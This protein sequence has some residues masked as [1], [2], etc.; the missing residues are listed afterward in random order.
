MIDAH[1]RDALAEI[2]H[3]Q[4][5]AGVDDLTLGALTRRRQRDG[6]KLCQ[7]QALL[8]VGR[9]DAGNDLVGGVVA[10]N[11][12]IADVGQYPAGY[13]LQPFIDFFGG[14]NF[15]QRAGQVA[16]FGQLIVAGQQQVFGLF[17]SGDIR[18]H[19]QNTF[20]S[21]QD[22]VFHRDQPGDDFAGAGAEARL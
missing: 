5:L 11:V 4:G 12:H 9:I 18:Q 22:D 14:Q 16:G 15:R 7:V 17:A 2:V 8:L 21:V 20:L 6:R 13:L 19:D 3:H 10:G 1:L